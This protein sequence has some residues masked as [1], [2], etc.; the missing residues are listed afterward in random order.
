MDE[1]KRLLERFFKTTDHLQEDLSTRWRLHANRRTII[2]LSAIGG[3]AIFG[4]L[5]M[6]RPPANF[7]VNQLVTV[8]EGLV[9]GEIAQK[10][11]DDGVVRSSLAFRIFVTLIGRERTAQAGDYLFK[12]PKDIFT[13]ARSISTGAF[14]LE[15]ERIR[16]AEG[17]TTRSMAMIF[18]NRLLRFDP[19]KFLALAQPM[20]GYLFPDTYFF[21]P[22]ATEDTVIR[23]MRENFDLKTA[24]L[25][26]EIASST[27]SLDDVV[28]LASIIEREAR[29]P[30]DRRMISGVLHNRL[31]RGMALQVDVTFLYTLGKNTFQLTLEDLKSDSPYNTY[32]HKGLPPT[33]IGSPSLDALDAALHPTKNDYL[34]YL[35]DNSGVTHFSKTY[36][37]HLRYK[38]MYLGT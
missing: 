6:I 11:E 21:L 20:E 3:L 15:P 25:Q 4:Y 27:K 22:N 1:L 19:E 5:T 14:G 7:P 17:A 36:E 34:F 9:L 31:K 12:E 10:L 30:K 37:Q 26:A 16:I 32:K 38:R 35:A 23:T 2:A 18:D 8:P 33:P 13:I 29:I 28:N 24:E